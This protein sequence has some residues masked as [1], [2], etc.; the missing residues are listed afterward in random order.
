M[1]AVICDGAA[2]FKQIHTLIHGLDMLTVLPRMHVAIFSA[3]S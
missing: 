3:A 2:K 1:P